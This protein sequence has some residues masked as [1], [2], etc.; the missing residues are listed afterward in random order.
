MAGRGHPRSQW[1][2]GDQVPNQG[3][4]SQGLRRAWLVQPEVQHGVQPGEAGLKDLLWNLSVIVLKI[5]IINI[6]KEIYDS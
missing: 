4:L 5:D 6:N 1:R 2:G 3:A